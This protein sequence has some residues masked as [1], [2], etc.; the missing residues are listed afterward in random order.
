MT[1]SCS[2]SFS[3]QTSSI[4]KLHSRRWRQPAKNSMQA[5]MSIILKLYVPEY[6]VT[7][8]FSSPHIPTPFALLRCSLP[9]AG[10]RQRQGR[11]RSDPVPE[12]FFRSTSH[13][14]RCPGNLC[15]LLFAQVNAPGEWIQQVG[16]RGYSKRMQC[17]IRDHHCRRSPPEEQEEQE[18]EEDEG[19][20]RKRS[21]YSYP[22]P[23]CN[24]RVHCEGWRGPLM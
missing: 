4:P 3:T 9:F 15:P 5:N 17:R 12:A 18:D 7:K 8:S 6:T 22:A 13:G 14:R 21:H 24:V 10:D 2:I 16:R 1:I 19:A 20:N 23:T 11:R